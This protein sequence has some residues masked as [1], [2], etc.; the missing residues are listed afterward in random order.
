MCEDTCIANDLCK[1]SL[2]KY[3]EKRAKDGLPDPNGP[4][5]SR[6]PSDK[7]VGKPRDICGPAEYLLSWQHLKERNVVHTIGEKL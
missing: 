7:S 5:S 6:V 2:F 3:F 1:M 4:L